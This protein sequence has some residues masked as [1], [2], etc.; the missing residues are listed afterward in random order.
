MSYIL[1]QASAHR[2]P[3]RDETVQCVVT[4]PPYFGAVRQYEGT[5]HIVEWGGAL[6]SERS[7]EAYVC[8]MVEVGREMRRILKPD[9]A[10]WL[11]IGEVY[12]AS[13][14]G[15]GGNQG[16]RASWAT[17][18]TR[19]GYRMP[20][21]G[22]KPKDLTL[23]PF[24]V[25]E[26]LRVDGW[27][28]RS[29]VVWRKPA[30]VEPMRLDRPALSHEYLFLLTKARHYSTRDPGE[31]WWGHSVWDINPS[32]NSAHPGTFPDELP[33]RCI[34]ASS[35]PEDVV[36]DPFNGSGTTG[37]VALRLGRRYV[38]L[39]LSREY[40]TQQAIHRVDPLAG[41][42]QDARDGTSGQQVMAL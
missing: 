41:A 24:K 7:P 33:R 2:L 9:G 26:A 29:T 42:A 11:N 15:G 10:F 18:N 1:A 32:L 17:I 25:A 31:S 30:A 23:A 4:S 38:G 20:P 36:L 6:G 19:A 37:A 34:V 14:K 13:G 5:Q 40:L 35:H 12:A 39:D 3:L 22:Y 27:Y 28:L 16:D 21:A 8:H